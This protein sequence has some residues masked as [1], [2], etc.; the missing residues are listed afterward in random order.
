MLIVAGVAA[1]TAAAAI[2]GGL[3][4]SLLA[5]GVSLFVLGVLLGL[6]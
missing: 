3:G 6:V 1:G 2:I 5:L 4:W